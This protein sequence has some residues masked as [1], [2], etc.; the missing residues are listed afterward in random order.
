MEATVATM[1]ATVA[2]MEATVGIMEATVVIMEDTVDK[3]KMVA[4]DSIQVLKIP[5]LCLRTIM[6]RMEDGDSTQEL[7]VQA[8][9]IMEVIILVLVMRS[10]LEGQTTTMKINIY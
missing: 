5:P 2:T 8:P 7:E 3:I 9:A 6:T 4:G 1:E 10:I